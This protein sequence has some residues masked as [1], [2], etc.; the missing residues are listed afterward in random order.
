MDINEKFRQIA[1][2]GLARWLVAREGVAMPVIFDTPVTDNVSAFKTYYMFQEEDTKSLMNPSV[3]CN[4]GGRVLCNVRGVN[5][6][7]I[8]NPRQRFTW[9]DQ[10]TVYVN[11]RGYLETVNF[12]TELDPVTL[13]HSRVTRLNT[14]NFDKNP[15]WTFRGLEDGRLVYWDSSMMLSGVRRDVQGDGQGRIELSGVGQYPDN[16]TVE[17]SRTRIPMPDG[18]ENSYCEKNW[19]P[20]ADRPYTWIRW[21]RSGSVCVARYD[22]ANRRTT[23][24]EV[25][26]IEFESE[27]EIRGGSQLVEYN[28]RYWAFVHTCR[29]TLLNRKTRSRRGVY[30]HRLACFSKDLSLEWIS[31]EFSFSNDFTVEFCCGLAV[32]GAAAYVSF[33]EDDSVPVVI[34]FQAGLLFGEDTP[35][36]TD[37]VA[38]NTYAYRPMGLLPSKWER[39]DA[40]R[41]A[42]NLWKLYYRGD[43]RLIDLGLGLKECRLWSQATS[44][45]LNAAENDF[46]HDPGVQAVQVQEVAECLIMEGDGTG[47]FADIAQSLLRYSTV[48]HMTVSAQ[49]LLG[50]CLDRIGR[51]YDARI[52]YLRALE[53]CNPL[54]QFDK[55]R[56]WAKILDIDER[57][58]IWESDRT[59]ETLLDLWEN[60]HGDTKLDSELRDHLTDLGD[61]LAH[62]LGPD[63]SPWKL[64]YG[65]LVD[66]L[67]STILKR[68]RFNEIPVV[69]EIPEIS[70]IGADFSY[71]VEFRS[72]DDIKRLRL[73]TVRP[74]GCIGPAGANDRMKELGY[75]LCGMARGAGYYS[76]YHPDLIKRP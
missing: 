52:E 31:P 53:Y 64:S 54:L 51:P 63:S 62:R 35:C 24:R 21:V 48:K 8:V 10:P 17:S 69:D 32:H 47:L 7:F 26:G 72:V 56:L 36:L 73:G 49:I 46:D 12:L 76:W 34:K 15:E 75:K 27:Q 30:R 11:N 67:R 71:I 3:I 70:D 28:G 61:L 66:G 42:E 50:F 16:T 2:E 4:E 58:Q 23:F 5:Y 40:I 6:D 44:C 57:L 59:Y 74:G 1:D 20:V 55:I 37:H 68:H 19:M 33:S 43:I 38:E 45:I 39:R 9:S 18:Q 60:Y 14:S 25:P 65:R 41:Y 22:R 29:F 13:E